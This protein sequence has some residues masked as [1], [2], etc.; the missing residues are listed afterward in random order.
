VVA[1]TGPF[2]FARKVLL[3]PSETR[4][5]GPLGLAPLVPSCHFCPLQ[6]DRSPDAATQVIMLH[7]DTWEG[8]FFTADEKAS[9]RAIML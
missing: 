2:I 1:S 8:P 3:T 7:A 5:L 9:S 4:P 6:S